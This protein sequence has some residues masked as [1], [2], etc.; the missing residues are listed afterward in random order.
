MSCEEWPSAVTFHAL[1]GA[2]ELVW[3]TEPTVLTGAN[4]RSAC[5]CSGCESARRRGHPPGPCDGVL[6]THIEILGSAGLHCQFSDGHERGI[7]P[8]PYLRALTLTSE[9]RNGHER[10]L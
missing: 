6:L 7:Y 9:E 1:A 4:L 3:D 5:R 10:L 8:W 2:L